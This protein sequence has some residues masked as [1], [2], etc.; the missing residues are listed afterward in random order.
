MAGNDLRPSLRAVFLG[1]EFSRIVRFTLASSV[2]NIYDGW[3]FDLS[4]A[5]PDT[6][7]L[8]TQSL[9]QLHR[10]VPITLYHSDPLVEAGTPL[11]AVQGLIT[12]ARLIDGS[13]P[14]T[15]ALSG[16]DLGKLL[17]SCGPA[18]YRIRGHTWQQLLDKLLDPSWRA[19]T[20]AP[21]AW[22]FKGVRGIDV[23][24]RLK[25]GRVAAV[26]DYGK[27][28]QEFMPPVQI[29][30]GEVEYETLS[31]YARLT[32]YKGGSG[33]VVNVAADGWIQIFNPDDAAND[34]PLYTLNYTRDSRNQRIKGAELDLNGE[35]LYSNFEVYGSVIR[36]PYK[37]D[38]RDPNAGKF[39][40]SAPALEPLGVVRNFSTTDDEQYTPEYANARAAWRARQ[41]EFYAWSLTYTIQGHSLP[42]PGGRWTPLVEGN[43]A[44]VEDVVR[45]IRD[46][47]LVESVTRSQGAQGTTAQVVLRRRG[48][49]SG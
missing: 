23:N 25:V 32:G 26:Q 9:Q 43:I 34:A 28:Y 37:A 10:W 13:G 31:R 33:S 21:E 30:P 49:F 38:S 1:R 18:W 40:G 16:Y 42:G 17:D 44:E 19:V 29:A 20:L 11:P 45:G 4:G 15:L 8:L 7:K 5:D 6:I 47:L 27:K 41:A 22:G 3:S 12:R 36:M 14:T 35:G 24:K 2:T 46:R 48:L 39:H